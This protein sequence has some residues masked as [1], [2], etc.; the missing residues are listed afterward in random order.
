MRR[1]LGVLFVMFVG[2]VALGPRV[3]SACDIEVKVIKGEKE[4]YQAGDQFMVSVKV[5]LTHRVCPEAINKTKFK[6]KGLKVMKATGWK[7][8][9]S[10][11]YQRKLIVKVVDDSVGKLVLSA[12]RT[13]DKDG[14]VGTLTLA[15]MPK[16]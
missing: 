7:Q 6:M 3:A 13:C 11:E 10:V 14:G 12:I 1:A 2:W 16:E 15:V 4:A 8:V 9:S 5:V